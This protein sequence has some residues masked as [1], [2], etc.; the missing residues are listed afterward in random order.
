MSDDHLK[1]PPTLDVLFITGPE[2]DYAE[3]QRERSLISH[4]QYF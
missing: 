1:Y 3:R 4:R 2:I